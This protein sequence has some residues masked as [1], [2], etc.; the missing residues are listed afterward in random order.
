MSWPATAD[1][2]PVNVGDDTYAPL[3]PYGWGLRTDPQRDRLTALVATL[4]AGDAQ[5]AVQAVL[6]APV[7]DGTHIDPART[8][9]A[10]RLLADAAAELD[11]TD[12]DTAA[13]A[14]V[15]VSVVRDLAQDVSGA[16]DAATTADAEHALMSGDASGAVDLLA[17]VLGV[18]TAPPVAS[19]TH[20]SLS[21]SITAFGRPVTARV[22]VTAPGGQP[23]GSVQVLVD[24]TSVATVP[25]SAD[26]TA[27]VRL[28]ADVATGRHGVTAV[29]A[30][31]PAADPPVTGSTSRAA[32]LV[33]VR[34]LPTVRTDGTDW[35]LRRGDPK[36]VHVQVTGVADVTPTGRVDVWVNGARKGSATL[37]GRGAAVV[38]LPTSTRTS[39]V[40][41]TYAGD[42]TY[43][44]WAAVPR[45]LVVR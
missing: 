10:V 15:V 23:E 29:Y 7:W 4:P 33:V 30:G 12:R 17:D 43:L 14:G 32:T 26:G 11:G 16:D 21:S 41:V 28:P 40:V 5:D 44:P 9:P 2:V 20:L 38:T 42:D 6:D 31:A 24:G 19:S 13:A 37:D 45:L 27:S 39:L 1:Q 34:T 3:F 22:T 18:S 35:T 25:L 8:G 36:Q